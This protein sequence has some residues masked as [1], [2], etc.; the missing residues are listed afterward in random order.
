MNRL[1]G[2]HLHYPES[3]HSSHVKFLSLSRWWFGF[4]VSWLLYC[5]AFLNMIMLEIIK[6][7]LSARTVSYKLSFWTIFLLHSTF[8][9]SVGIRTRNE[10]YQG[11][12]RIWIFFPVADWKNEVDLL[13][14][15]KY[16]KAWREHEKRRN[17]LLNEGIHFLLSLSSSEFVLGLAWRHVSLLLFQ[18]K[19]RWSVFFVEW[20]R[21]DGAS[22]P[23]TVTNAFYKIQCSKIGICLEGKEEN[24]VESLRSRTEKKI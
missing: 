6:R 4:V 18:N 16:W 14:K 10:S 2:A 15:K 1:L 24:H 23:K 13:N 9:S 22:M 11:F 8:H 17:S 3:T 19:D 12:I 5:D 7:F 20:T 21:K